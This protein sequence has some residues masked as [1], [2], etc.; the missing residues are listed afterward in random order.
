M[1]G[2]D[3]KGKMPKAMKKPKGKP[4]AMKMASATTTRS[5]NGPRRPKPDMV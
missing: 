4:K 5:G 2:M 3:K 1:R